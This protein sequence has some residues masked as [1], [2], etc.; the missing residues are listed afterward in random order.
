MGGVLELWSVSS[1][2][3]IASLPTQAIYG[4]QAVEFTADGKTLADCGLGT[5]TGELE[6][7]NVAS[8]TLSA[9][10]FTFVAY[11]SALG[12]SHDNKTLA[13]GGSDDT[14]D[15]Y[16]EVW[17]IS[18]GTVTSGLTTSVKGTTYGLAFTPDG[19]T[20]ATGATFY[21]DGTGTYIGKL[22]LW[23]V[24]T[25]T[26]KTSLPTTGSVVS[27]IAISSDGKVLAD[28]CGGFAELWNLSTNSLISNL[29]AGF[30]ITSNAFSPNGKTLLLG[31]LTYIVNQTGPSPGDIGNLQFWDV[32]TETATDS[33]SS[34]LY[35]ELTA[36]AF[37]SDGTTAAGAGSIFSTLDNQSGALNLWN[38][39]TGKQLASL[40]TS[41]S[42][43]VKSIAFSPSGSTLA[44]GGQN[45]SG[46]VLELWNPVTGNQ[47]ANLPTTSAGGVT[48][49]AYSA[50]GSAMATAGTNDA[51]TVLE[52]WNTASNKLSGTLSPSENTM[53]NAISFA[54]SGTVLA[55]GGQ[56][57]TGSQTTGLVELW[58]PK[59]GTRLTT[60][61]APGVTDVYGVAFSPDGSTLATCG[62]GFNGSGPRV[63]EL[64][65]WNVASGKMIASVAL[66]SGTTDAYSVSFS[67]DGRILFVGTSAG[68]QVVNIASQTVL[69]TY[70]VGF[71]DASISAQMTPSGTQIGF[72]TSFGSIAVSPNPY[73]SFSLSSISLSP[74]TVQGG[75]SSTGTVTLAS[76]ASEVGAT[77]SLSSSSPSVT[78]PA[79][80]IFAPG[81][82]TATFEATTKGVDTQTSVTLTAGTGSSAKATSLIV[83]PSALSAVSFTS[84]T[85]TGGDTTTGTVTL[86][87]V[88]G[89]SG[90]IVTLAS[91]SKSATVP[92]T[93]TIKAGQK[94][95]TFL[96]STLPVTKQTF[97]VVTANSGQV[98]VSATLTVDPPAPATVSFIPSTVVGT[99]ESTGTV[100]LTS[101]APHGGLVVK[102][103]SNSK[104]A[105]VNGSV[106]V[107]DGK[108]S[109]TFTVKTLAVSTQ[110]SVT[111]TAT[112]NGLSQKAVVKITPPSLT[113]LA[114]VPA[115]VN[116]GTSSTA[117][118][119]LNAATPAGG[120]KISLA[121]S[122]S[123]ATVTTPLVITEGRTSATF[124][125]KSIAVAKETNATITASQGT[126]SKTAVL[127]IQPPA[128]KALILSPASV[129]GGKSVT[130]TLTLTSP[131]PSTGLSIAITSTS[132]L[133]P[134]PTT[135]TV[136][137]GKT[138]VTFQIKTAVTKSKSTATIA[139]S[140]G[141]K[142]NSAVL[143]IQT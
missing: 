80:V 69:T 116:G 56:N 24:A 63:A 87:G 50:D 70:N 85:I 59:S 28:D 53:I 89:P 93:V 111:I 132:S 130:A 122:S 42:L 131:A 115:S 19:A 103:S 106:I 10:L 71:L 75:D 78:V 100:T 45:A 67:N 114:I 46:G 88:A 83:N 2:N 86:G 121:S 125:I 109:A 30:S 25:G 7:W 129:K 139:A 52:L 38:T 32:A 40:N 107:P 48:A 5:Y 13:I 47:V 143:T 35:T 73:V 119:K 37:S 128:V 55:I 137:A 6:L 76:P 77:V 113:S 64:Q 99:L 134:V 66:A 3:F 61:S 120:I 79:A 11:P 135:V 82:T 72:I 123:S 41:A 23:D 112:L 33:I 104:S 91:N 127:A 18:T 60:L 8:A 15:G 12:L 108:T 74:T 126:L 142:T 43:G 62:N 9:S 140:V 118:L 133:A 136:L 124:V 94:S 101:V 36:A 102:L 44:N 81:A 1:G 95:A 96:I 26:A 90:V 34:S 97:A 58:N 51:G 68:I 117:I 14:G 57:V 4:V 17:D 110:Q 29:N 39:S 92:K 21:D 141:G 138:S 84:P 98:Y 49:I 31:G 54:P 22:A 27:S 20:L 65:I 16:V 105:T